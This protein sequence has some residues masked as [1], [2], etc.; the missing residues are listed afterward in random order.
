MMMMMMTKLMVI[1]IKNKRQNLE[2]KLI[3]SIATEAKGAA[4]AAA[5]LMTHRV[6]I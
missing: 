5:V 4:V 2:L 6:K 3:E 1:L